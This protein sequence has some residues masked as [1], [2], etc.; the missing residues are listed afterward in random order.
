MPAGA[1]V[2]NNAIQ[3]ARTTLTEAAFEQLISFVVS[4]L[5]QPGERL[6]PER[7]LCQQLGI[8]R[9]SLREALKAMEMIG[10]LTSRVGD[11]TF[12]CD[13]SEFLSR[14]LLWAL[15]GTDHVELRNI[16]EARSLIEKDLAALAAERA[17]PE[18]LQ[19]IERTVVLMRDAIDQGQSILEMDMAFHLSVARAAH[20]DVLLNAVQLLRNLLRQWISLKLLIPAIPSLVLEQHE[21][22]YHGIEARKPEVA[23]AAM[24]DHLQNTAMLLSR[25]VEAKSAPAQ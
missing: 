12:V 18:E 15:T 22:I 14:P 24:W 7:E 25:L 10:M 4:G 13:R 19:D 16:M 11:G 6:P 3:I 21:A 8:A 20:N 17:S 1:K 9:T 2:R 5:W 23:R